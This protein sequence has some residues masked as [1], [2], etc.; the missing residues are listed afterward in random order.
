M[1]IILKKNAV[2]Q[3]S[4]NTIIYKSGDAIESVALILKGRVVIAKNNVKMTVSSGYFLGLADL[5]EGAYLF[6]SIACEEVMLF[7]FDAKNIQ[8]IESILSV[9]KDYSGLVIGSLNNQLNQLVNNYELISSKADDIYRTIKNAL[10]L[11]KDIQN[12]YGSKVYQLPLA[13]NLVEYEETEKMNHAFMPYIKQSAQL[14][15]ELIKNY[16]SYGVEMALYDIEERATLLMPMVKEINTLSNYLE[17]GLLILFNHGSD[18]LYK[19]VAVA[20]KENDTRN[21]RYSEL[22]ILVKQ[23][24]DEIKSVSELLTKRLGIAVE[25]DQQVLETLYSDVMN[26][27]NKEEV[28]LQEGS[29]KSPVETQQLLK[30]SCNQILQFSKLESSFCDEFRGMLEWLDKTKENM[31]TDTETRNKRKHLT[32]LFFKLY[33]A[34]FLNAAKQSDSP[35]AVELFLKYGFVDERF[36]ELEQ[37]VELA[38]LEDATKQENYC[39]VFNIK[40][41]LMQIYEGKKEPSKNEFDMEYTDM[42]RRQLKTHEIT[43]EQERECL[44]NTEIKVIYEIDNMFRYNMRLVNGKITTFVPVLMGTEM[45]GHIKDSYLSAKKINDE[46]EKVL[47]IDYSLFYREMM[48]SNPEKGITREVVMKEYFPDVIMMPT[49]GSK[50]IM[51][52]EITGKKRASEGRFI[53]PAMLEGRLSDMILQLLGRFRWELCRAVQGMSWNDI[54]H[55]SLT[56]E[57]CDFIQFFRKNRDLSE[58]KKEKVKAQLQKSRN[59]SKEFFVL[60][61][62]N[63]IRYESTGS[64]RLNKVAREILAMYCP[65]SKEIRESMLTRPMFEQAMLRFNREHAKKIKEWEMKSVYWKKDNLDVPEELLKTKAYYVEM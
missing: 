58:E 40:D 17:Q 59:S 57:Y 13:E 49:V 30:N 42:I 23:L 48:Y 6:D 18:C 25:V 47:L 20:A 28:K 3:I 62:E 8:D 61:Y 45:I 44:N 65:F 51:W 46:I 10:N 1:G 64:V 26:G 35:L 39:N 38:N 36:F 31:S 33:K 56:S 63:W 60:D 15:L 11:Y 19:I 32:E 37:L 24:L 54:K 50:A 55:K 41:W 12:S 9:N 34:V 29:K 21:K 4:A 16:Y 52:Q 43:P 7:V 22:V 14:P 27:E 5:Y 53:L 2:N